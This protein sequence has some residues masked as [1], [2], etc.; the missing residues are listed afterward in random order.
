M[1]FR[2]L[3]WFDLFENVREFFNARSRSTKVTAGVVDTQFF[4]G[5]RTLAMMFVLYGHCLFFPLQSGISNSHTAMVWL[6]SYAGIGI[7]PAEL[8]VDTFFFLSGFL[9]FH[10]LLK[11]TEKKYHERLKEAAVAASAE[12][13]S[14]VQPTQGGSEATAL[15]THNDNDLDKSLNAQSHTKTP[16]AS[17]IY[18]TPLGPVD[19][20]LLYLRR[21]LRM[22]PVVMLTLVTATWLL[23]YLP[24]NDV[25]YAT[26]ENQYTFQSCREYWWRQLLFIIN[27]N[28]NGGWI[29]CMDW[30]WYLSCDFQMFMAA[31]IALLP[32]YSHPTK[33]P[34]VWTLFASV[35]ILIMIICQNYFK[36]FKCE[37]TLLG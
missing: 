2:L 35:L 14:S 29:H 28:D 23:Q 21:W 22:T 32:Y 1:L 24:T 30:F 16:G 27:L 10:L 8:A 33:G 6:R 20:L 31:P 3:V 12:E 5:L 37:R 25:M 9:T 15:I 13:A 7:F 26:Y 4:E 34:W 19:T 11:H 36:V 18:H 17:G